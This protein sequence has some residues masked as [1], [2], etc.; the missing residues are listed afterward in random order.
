MRPYLRSLFL[1]QS[2]VLPSHGLLLKIV[3][4][5]LPSGGLSLP[6][7]EHDTG[8]VHFDVEYE[9]LFFRAFKGEVVEGSED[10]IQAVHYLWAMQLTPKEFVAEDGRKYQAQTW[11][12][13]EQIMRGVMAIVG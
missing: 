10:D 6:P 2:I 13:R 5:A 8:S 12:L 1:P 11:L 3:S 9:G 4:I 7:I